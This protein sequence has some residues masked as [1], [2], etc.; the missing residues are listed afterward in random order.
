MKYF[1]LLLAG[2]TLAFV[3]CGTESDSDSGSSSK[4]SCTTIEQGEGTCVLTD[5]ANEASCTAEG[6]TVGSA[7]EAGE[8]ILCKDATLTDEDTGESIQGDVYIYGEVTYGLLEA[9][10]ALDGKDVCDAFAE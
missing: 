10:A 1:K 7:C 5:A 6:G 2:M 4:I 3:G 9:F 8:Q